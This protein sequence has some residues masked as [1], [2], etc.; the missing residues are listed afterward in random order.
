MASTPLADDVTTSDATLGEIEGILVETSET[1]SDRVVLLLHG[2]AYALGSA[3]VSVGLASEVGRR[4]RARAYSIDYRLAP[5]HPYPA[6][7]DDSV[8][9]YRGLLDSG[10]DARQIHLAN[11]PE[12]LVAAALVRQRRVGCP[13]R[14]RG[15]DVP[16]GGLDAHEYDVGQRGQRRS[17]PVGAGAAT[18]CWRLRD[19]GGCP[20][21]EPAVRRPLRARPAARPGRL[22]RHPSGRCHGSGSTRGGVRRSRRARR[23][24]VC[25]MSFRASRAC[26]TKA[27]R[28]SM[29]WARSSTAGSARSIPRWLREGLLELGRV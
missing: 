26:S 21:G 9:A 10:V 4:A 23:L 20:G 25:R 17:A 8:A 12:R 7:V 11:R 29:R 2:G 22:A 18:S 3:R 24:A 27:S 13:S 16:V 1:R 14:L 15:P 19:A 28:R 5:E 6:A